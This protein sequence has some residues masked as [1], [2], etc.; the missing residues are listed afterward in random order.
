MVQP[1]LLS[2]DGAYAAVFDLGDGTV[3]KAYRQKYTTTIAVGEWCDHEAIIRATWANEVRAYTQL[4][5]ADLDL[6]NFV[7]RFYGQCDPLDLISSAAIGSLRLMPGCGI[8]LERIDGR[9]A[10]LAAL[11]D[12]LREAVT[13]ILWRI[14]DVIE[15][16]NVWDSS[17]FVPGSR[18]EFTIIDF[19]LWDGVDD[20]SEPLE[21]RG[22]LLE[23][24]RAELQS[25]GAVDEAAIAITQSRADEYQAPE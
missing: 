21:R 20:Y 23:H 4:M 16:G 18:A 2:N 19:A 25:L 11:D 7:P 9:A 1:R 5:A 24:Q 13:R 8:R 3:V 10:K 6:R 14:R 22:Y 15:P 17:C 12:D